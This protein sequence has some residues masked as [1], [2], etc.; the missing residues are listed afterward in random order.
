MGGSVTVLLGLRSFIL[1][2]KIV[3]TMKSR[4]RW[5]WWEGMLPW[6]RSKG[7][8]VRASLL[9]EVVGEAE[10]VGVGQVEKAT[11]RVIVLLDMES[12]ASVATASSPIFVADILHYHVDTHF[13]DVDHPKWMSVAAG[14]PC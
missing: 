9:V 5:S 1:S 2:L 4:L 7:P 14:V 8:V 10:V 11:H 13:V 6:R 12:V 3:A